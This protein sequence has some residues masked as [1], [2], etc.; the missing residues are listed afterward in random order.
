RLRRVRILCGDWRRVVTDAVLYGPGTPTGILLDPP[1][2]QTRRDPHL[3]A[4]EADIATDVRDWAVAHG[5]DPRLRVALCVLVGEHQMPPTWTCYA[6]QA[7]GGY[8]NER[9]HGRGRGHTRQECMWFS[10]ACLPA[11]QLA[12]L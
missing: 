4:V 3:Y 12:L 7:R 10:P 6:W 2:D 5:D 11:T 9:Y 8:S 1:Y